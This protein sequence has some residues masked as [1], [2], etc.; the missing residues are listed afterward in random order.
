MLDATMVAVLEK[1]ELKTDGGE[2]YP[3]EAYAYVPDREKSSTWK[4]RLWQTPQT[5]ETA[6]Q[7]GLAVAALGP[8]GYRGNRVQ[9]PAADLPAVK[10]RVLRAWLKVHEDD[11]REDAPDVLKEHDGPHRAED[12]AMTHL[13]MA[14]RQMMEHPECW[15]MLGPLMDLVHQLQDVM[16]D[17]AEE[18]VD[19]P[20][21]EVV[22]VEE[23]YGRRRRR[24]MAKVITEEDGQYCVRSEET[25]RLFGC[26]NTVDQANARMEQIDSFSA[27]KLAD[28][29]TEQLTGWFA[30]G[31]RMA[32]ASPAFKT[33]HE[34]IGDE[35]AVRA[36]RRDLGAKLAQL[37][38]AHPD[39]LPF[40]K[41]EEHRYTLGP[42]YVPGWEDAHGEF[43]DEKTLQKALW[44]W[45]RKD[46]RNIYLQHSK[47]V[48]GEMV[49]MLT[50]PFELETS[51]SVPNQ[52]VTKY[53]FPPETPFMGVV[54][55]P[56]A[57]DLVKNGALRGY[58]IGGSARRMEA[59]LPV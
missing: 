46:D 51:L 26:Y 11:S 44:S 25:N 1:Q 34:L 42:V 5:K 9:I 49:E 3:P 33:V 29:T 59:A 58:S 19:D 15:P 39:A 32:V 21:G 53:T 16:I 45:V 52:G 18:M 8:G 37:E 4:L 40:T 14:Y 17:A 48:A 2:K 23:G 13:L 7:V 12:D 43:T 22:Y 31:F 35:L 28:A 57:W 55:E 47:Q 6:L 36:S 24:K 27:E 50:W 20:D 41:Q 56:W 38:K 54:W 30:N 10:R